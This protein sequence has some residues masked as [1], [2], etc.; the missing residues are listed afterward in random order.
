[1]KYDGKFSVTW[2]YEDFE[3]KYY[4]VPVSVADVFEPYCGHPVIASV[5]GHSLWKSVN[6]L[7]VDVWEFD[8]LEDKS[9]HYLKLAKAEAIEALR[10]WGFE[11]E[12]VGE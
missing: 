3:D 12:G 9:G 5:D 10:R 2:V 4:L 7:G 1:M 6:V 8:H 11:I